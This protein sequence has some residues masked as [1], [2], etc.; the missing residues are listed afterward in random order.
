M[1]D[2]PVKRFIAG[3]VCPGCGE[4]DKLKAWHEGAVQF[5]ECVRC[6]FT[7]RTSTAD[8]E[9]LPTRLDRPKPATGAAMQFYPRRPDRKKTD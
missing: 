8:A 4:Q 5:R 9:G 1:N 6:G 2:A 3:A 7:D